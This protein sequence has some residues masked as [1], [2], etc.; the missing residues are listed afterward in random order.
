M[1]RAPMIN[2][3][4]TFHLPKYNPN[5][6]CVLKVITDKLTLLCLTMYSAIFLQSLLWD[7]NQ[8]TSHVHTRREGGGEGGGR[9]KFYLRVELIKCID[10]NE[11]EAL[12]RGREGEGRGGAG[13]R[14]GRVGQRGQKE[15][16]PEGG[17][18]QMYWSQWRWGIEEGR[19][20][21][22]G[23]AGGR[24]GGEGGQAG[25]RGGQ[26]GRRKFYLRVE[27]I[28]RIDPNEGEALKSGR[29]GGGR[30]GGQAGGREGWR[31]GRVGHS[32]QKE[33][34]PGGQNWSNVLILMKVR[35]WGGVGREGRAGEGR[36]EGR[37][38]LPG[39]W[40]WSNVLI[41]MKVRHWGGG[42]P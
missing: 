8:M 32:G 5:M 3:N 33:I 35:H 23:Q 37:E 42:P 31:E 26:R 11:G 12:K 4:I 41:Q 16:L 24:E 9:R 22:G 17:I 13:G 36:M 25:G 7:L 20:G 14:E 2:Q 27:L 29:E 39:G 40:N 21:G 10:P 34:L 19:E 38:I 6:F 15:I 30:G 1:N 18:D 28:K